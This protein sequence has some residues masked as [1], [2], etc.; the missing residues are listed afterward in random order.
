[1]E[2]GLDKELQTMT[3]LSTDKNSAIVFLL[4]SVFS[5]T[6]LRVFF[7]GHLPIYVFIDSVAPAYLRVIMND[8]K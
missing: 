8:Q 1:M 5:T 4:A 6:D 2:P 3:L 7:F